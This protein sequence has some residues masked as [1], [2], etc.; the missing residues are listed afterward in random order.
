MREGFWETRRTGVG[1]IGKSTSAASDKAGAGGRHGARPGLR[2][3]IAGRKEKPADEYSGVWGDERGCEASGVA[4]ESSGVGDEEGGREA[5]GVAENPRG[6]HQGV[7]GGVELPQGIDT[8]GVAEFPWGDKTPGVSTK[9]EG[10]PGEDERGRGGD[11]TP[12]ATRSTEA[13]GAG[14]GDELRMGGLRTAGSPC[15]QKG[16]AA[17]IDSVGTLL[18]HTALPVGARPKHGALARHE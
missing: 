7:G 4:H 2:G 9:G 6:N 10:V 11:V 16:T 14:G 5:S 13:R 8:P 15:P 1:D 17:D 18:R 3:R 12:P